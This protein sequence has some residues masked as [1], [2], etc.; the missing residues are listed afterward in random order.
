[1]K[2]R[3]FKV[4]VIKTGFDDITYAITDKAEAEALFRKLFDAGYTV[5]FLEEVQ[6]L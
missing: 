4:K 6:E 3:I 2:R 1:M 5:R